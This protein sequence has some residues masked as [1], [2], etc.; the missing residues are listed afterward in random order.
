MELV[1]RLRDTSFG[2]TKTSSY[3]WYGSG[4]P[5]IAALL[6]EAADEI[7]SLREQLLDKMR[8]EDESPA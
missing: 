2:I 4:S 7:E 6:N 8:W 3:W 1:Q 5:E